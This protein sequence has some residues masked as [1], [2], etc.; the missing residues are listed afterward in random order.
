M[1]SGRVA[2]ARITSQPLTADACLAAVDAPSA[3]GIGCF[4]GVVRDHDQ[5]RSVR[6][7]EYEAHPSAETELQALCEQAAA[8]G[9]VAVAVEHR[10]GSLAIGDIAVVVAVSGQHRAEALAATAELIDAIKASV[11]IWKHQHFTDGTAEW[12]GAGNC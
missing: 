2:L 1:P 7:L 9:V 5:C 12:T 8:G 3:G 4:I 11:P 6:S 10:I